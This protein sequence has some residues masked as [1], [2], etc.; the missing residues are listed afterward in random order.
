M[1]ANDTYDP[2]HPTPTTP[3]TPRQSSPIRAPPRLETRNNRAH[4]PPK[5]WRDDAY[6]L[7][8]CQTKA[9]AVKCFVRMMTAEKQQERL[10]ERIIY[11]LKSLPPSTC[12]NY[13]PLAFSHAPFPIRHELAS[14][15]VGARLIHS[16]FLHSLTLLSYAE[17]PCA[18]L[19]DALLNHESDDHSLESY[20]TLTTQATAAEFVDFVAPSIRE[21]IDVEQIRTELITYKPF[22]PNYL[23]REED[24]KRFTPSRMAS[25]LNKICE[26]K[27]IPLPMNAKIVLF[28]EFSMYLVKQFAEGNIYT[29]DFLLMVREALSRYEIPLARAIPVLHEDIPDLARHLAEQAD[30]STPEP[31]ESSSTIP[32]LDTPCSNDHSRILP[33]MDGISEIFIHNQATL[34]RLKEDLENTSCITLIHHE[35][36]RLMPNTVPIDML[37][38]RTFKRVFHVF[39]TTSPYLF[40]ATI[41]LLRIY[42]TKGIIY[43]WRPS[44]FVR[45]MIEQHAW[46]PILADINVEMSRQ[47]ELSEFSL[48]DLSRKL[49]NVPF[50][51]HAR[52][53]SAHVRPSSPASDHRS[54][55]VSLLHVAALK[56]V[57][58]HQPT[59][60]EQTAETQA[61]INE[62]AE[63][64]ERQERERQEQE[65]LEQER[66]ERRERRERERVEREKE[67]KR[68]L[69]QR[70]KELD[71]STEGIENQKRILDQ[72]LQ[73][74]AQERER[75]RSLRS[76]LSDPARDRSRSRDRDSPRSESHRFD[77]RHSDPR[78][79]ESHYSDSRRSDPHRSESHHRS[80][81]RQ[82]RQDSRQ[83]SLRDSRQDSRQRYSQD[84]EGQRPSTSSKPPQKP[85]PRDATQANQRSRH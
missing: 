16:S 74:A 4:Q 44:G 24:R 80:D 1:E 81:S 39:A 52:I 55:L 62:A 29:G 49:F 5:N 22:P 79:S 18:V 76:R 9:A 66:Q 68:Q 59:A 35:P 2:A 7:E 53:F 57:C 23:A 50:C 12:K 36:P 43:S 47:L 56:F 63:E 21:E 30:L 38:I 13:A 60:G 8:K 67:E 40:R 78:H 72:Q 3:A 46:S 71:L 33:V 48:S 27:D 14:R 58:L 54:L 73:F 31:S 26:A 51:R 70:E 64:R 28:A 45:M 32:F 15:I 20:L 41:N 37:T 77:P 34:N 82:S 42:E 17:M 11:V 65:R 19:I 10:I 83:V 85:S 69:E 75:I 61:A 84:T 6:F 25:L